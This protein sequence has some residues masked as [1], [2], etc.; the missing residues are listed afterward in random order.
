M[1]AAELWCL[2]LC[3]RRSANRAGLAAVAGGSVGWLRLAVVVHGA[4]HE[5][6]VEQGLPSGC[7]AAGAVDQAALLCATS[8]G[9]RL[10]VAGLV[11]S[12][13]PERG[14]GLGDEIELGL[15]LGLGDELGCCSCAMDLGG[16][17][18][19]RMASG[20]GVWVLI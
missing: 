7:V 19:P 9:R 4:P 12:V 11:A 10:G 6:G 17:S 16:W 15:A 3:C 13:G 5:T 2:G 20:V 8:H 14:L 1:F 18:T